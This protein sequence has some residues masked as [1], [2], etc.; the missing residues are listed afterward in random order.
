VFAEG[1]PNI[2]VFHLAAGA[3]ALPQS[4]WVNLVDFEELERLANGHE[5]F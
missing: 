2:H 1:D 5:A 3:V 4:N